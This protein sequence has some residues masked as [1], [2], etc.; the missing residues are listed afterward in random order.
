VLQ[1]FLE[2]GVVGGDHRQPLPA[3]RREAGVVGDEGRLDVHQ[4][5]ALGRGQHGPVHRPPAH[6]AVF[7][8]AGHRPAGTRTTPGSS[9]SAP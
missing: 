1:I 9:G 2:Q 4:V 6:Q 7:P 5:A 3:G 8:V